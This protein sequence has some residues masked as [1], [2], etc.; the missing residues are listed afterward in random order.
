VKSILTKREEEILI[1]ILEEITSS[2]IAAKLNLSVRT[3]D[4][5][6][7]NILRKTN[8]KTLVGVIKFAIKA[9]LIEDYHF[10]RE[11]GKKMRYPPA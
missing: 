4:T 6:R 10:K 3:V 9:G 8:C 11:S 2:E 1:L 7:K 5:H